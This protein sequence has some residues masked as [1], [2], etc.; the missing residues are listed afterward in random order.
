MDSKKDGLPPAVRPVL[1]P[2]RTDWTVRNTGYG[3]T[4]LSWAARRGH[5]GVVKMLLEQ[6]DTFY[7][8][9]PLSW[10]AGEGHEGVIKMLFEREDVNPDQAG[11]WHDRPPISWAARSGH[12][13]VVKILFRTR[14]C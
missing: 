10:A 4:P 12:E 7:D 13:G 8:R 1:P 11:S 14:G 6:A 2:G 3:R 9:T 5:E